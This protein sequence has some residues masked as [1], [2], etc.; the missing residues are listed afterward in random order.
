MKRVLAL[1]ASASLFLGVIGCARDYD[2]RLDQTYENLRYQKRLDENLEKPADTKSNLATANI[3]VRPP[4]GL[5]GPNKEFGLNL[6]EPGKFDLTDTFF[7]DKGSLHVVARIAKPKAANTKKGPAPA[8]AKVPRGD[9]T[10]D[11]VDLLKIAYATD[12]EASKAKSE[13]KSG[14][15]KTNP[16]KSFDLHP[17]GK[18]V[19]VYVSGDKNSPVQ[20]ALIFEYPEGELKNLVSKIDLCLGS[21]RVGERCA[22]RLHRTG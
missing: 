5:K 14:G 9:F 8:E 22:T 13:T 15:G 20:V 7:D 11:L 10:A 2:V 12:F 3:Y 4:L 1:L 18:E 16:F 6:V 21:F 17:T 19:K